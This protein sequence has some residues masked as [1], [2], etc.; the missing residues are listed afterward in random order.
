MVSVSTKVAAALS[1][2]PAPAHR[3]AEA[4]D[5]LG[6][7]VDTVAEALDVAGDGVA[8]DG[9]DDALGLHGE[10]AGRRAGRR[11]DRRGLVGIGLEDEHAEAVQVHS[12][13]GLQDVGIERGLAQLGAGGQA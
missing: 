5:P 12:G 10:D 11:R 9:V 1:S 13:A 8:P 6:Q 3:G 2:P 7:V 4:E